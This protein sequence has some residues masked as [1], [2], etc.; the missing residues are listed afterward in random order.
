M[1][2]TLLG[3]HRDATCEQCG[4]KFEVNTSD[5][6]EGKLP[7]GAA[8]NHGICPNCRNI[9]DLN[10]RSMD[11]GDK[12]LV[13][14][15]LYDFSSPSRLD[16]IVFKYPGTPGRIPRDGPQENFAAKNYIKRLWGLP[17]EKLSIGWGDVFL[18]VDKDGV[19]QREIIR[20]P[21]NK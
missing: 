20:K 16:V 6:A 5:E 9:Q 11:G 8:I 4:C 14:K 7:R 17:G 13:L 2:T 1:A 3:Y 12:V 21:P 18:R 19:E 15:P 10:L